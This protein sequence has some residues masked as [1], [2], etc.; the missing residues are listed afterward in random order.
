[1]RNVKIISGFITSNKYLK[2]LKNI[3]EYNNFNVEI[4]KPKKELMFVPFFYKKYIK[5]MIIK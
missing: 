1:M 5:N 3:Y 2:K 4:I